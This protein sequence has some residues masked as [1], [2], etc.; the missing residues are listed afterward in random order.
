MTKQ[1]KSASTICSSSRLLRFYTWI[2]HRKISP[3]MILLGTAVLVGLG[4]IVFRYLIE[5]VSWVGY[6]WFPQLLDEWGKTYVVIVPAV[7]GLIVGPLVYFFACEA[8]MSRRA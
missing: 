2:S 7:G 3:D 1:K 5:I 6:V 8:K 4:A